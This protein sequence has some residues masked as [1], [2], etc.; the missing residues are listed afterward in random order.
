[1][2]AE[3]NADRPPQV[4]LVDDTP[5][6]QT[7][8]GGWLEKHGFDVA[9][10]D[11]GKK[12]TAWLKLNRADLVLTDLRMPD[13]DGLELTTSVCRRFPRVPVVL[14]T[15][16]GS[17]E[18]AALALQTGASSYVPKSHLKELLVPTLHDLLKLARG[19]GG[20]SSF[21]CASFCE[22]H[23]TLNNDLDEIDPVVETVQ[24]LV[25]DMGVCDESGEL[26]IGVAVEN[27]L[28]NAI[29]HGNLELEGQLNGN[30]RS[31]IQERNA[32][33][34]YGQRKVHAHVR[35]GPEEARIA[36][37]DEGPGFNVE[38][39]LNIDLPT[40]LAT[41]SGRG[42]VL[43]WALMDKVSFSPTGNK[44]TLTK[45]AD[46]G[47]MMEEETANVI[48]TRKLGTLLNLSDQREI[49][50]PSDRLIVGREADCDIV[51]ENQSVSRRH[52][53]LF[54]YEG[55]WFVRCLKDNGT[56]VL[57]D[58]R[59]KQGRVGPGTNITIGNIEF[60][61]NYNLTDLGAVGVTPPVDPF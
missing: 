25:R 7:L 5:T 27:A 56:V 46:V 60:Q 22:I 48:D 13:M 39:L 57:N 12:A 35:V 34:I 18:L 36:I 15:A 38:E 17:E 14:M 55:W 30:A 23:F 11:S 50:L 42:F 33:P 26:H 1:M 45:T 40:T 3:I 52:C 28:S 61:L 59:V 32:D 31:I 58:G 43:M 6:E 41:G 4:L 20:R 47:T 2:V 29:I 16:Y 19:N 49:E 9:I 21:R 54:V 10:A 44:V 37:Q 51:L 8:I 24:S 53:M